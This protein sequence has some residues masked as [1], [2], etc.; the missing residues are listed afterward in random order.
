MSWVVVAMNETR[1]E[2]IYLEFLEFFD[3]ATVVADKM[4]SNI[5]QMAYDPSEWYM[6]YCRISPNWYAN[7]KW[8]SDDDSVSVEI[9]DINSYEPQVLES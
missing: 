7:H 5:Y 9:C 4:I 6:E 3:E 1:K 2:I 8:F